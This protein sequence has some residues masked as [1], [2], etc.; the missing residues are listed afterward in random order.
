MTSL[1]PVTLDD[2]Y[3][4]NSGAIVLNAIQALV[5]LPLMQRR[6]DQAQ[7]LN[8]AG[9]I[10]GYRGSPLGGFDKTLWQAQRFLDEHKIKFT[11]GINEDL[12]A[13]AVWGSQQVNL[14]EGSLYDGVFGLWYGKGPGVDRSGDAFK[15]ANAAGT[16]QYGGVVALL[17]DDHACRSSTL[18][19]QS[20]YA[21]M[22]AMIP[23]LNPAHILDILQFGLFGFAL[24]RYSGCWVSL[25]TL[26]EIADSSASIILDKLI[27]QFNIPQDFIMPQGG[28]NIRRPDTPLEQERRLHNFKIPAIQAFVRAN[29]IDNIIYNPPQKRLGIVT[30]G[31]AYLD[32]LEAFNILGLTEEKLLDLGIGL[33]KVGLTWPLESLKLKHF[34]EGYESLFVIEEKRPL[35]ESQARDHLYSLEASKRPQIFGKTHPQ[36]GILLESTYELSPDRIAMALYTLL[37]EK[38]NPS[39]NLLKSIE[40]LDKQ[41]KQ[42]G[43]PS[44]LGQR[45][46]Y[47]CPGCPHNTSTKLPEG[48]EG[49]AGIGCHYMARWMNRKT[50]LFT[51]MGAE[52]VPWIGHAPF[53][54]LPHLFSNLGD[55][56]YFHSG[57]LAIRASVA[58]K[59]NITYKLLYNDAVAMTGG[60][61]VDGTL[62]VSQLANQLWAEGVQKVVI[63]TDD[64]DRYKNQKH[65]YPA[66]VTF[67]DRDD[68]DAVQ[69]Q[70]RDISGVTVLIYEQ[71][72]ATEKRRR[73]KRGLMEDPNRRIFINDAVCEGCGDCGKVSNCV[74]IA[75]L[76]TELGRK[77][78]IDQSACNKDFSCVKGF[79]PSFVSVEGAKIKKTTLSDHAAPGDH[80]LDIPLPEMSILLD[81]SYNI[82]ITGIGGTGIVTIGSLLGMAAHLEGKGCT[83]LD[84]TGLAQ[85]GGPVTSHLRISSSPE[86]ENASRIPFHKVDVVLAA[87]LVVTT[88]PDVLARLN[89]KKTTV[90]FDPHETMPGTFTQDADYNLNTQHMVDILKHHIQ[91][92]NM[93]Q[94][95]ANKISTAILGDSLFANIF[96]VG[97]AYQKGLIPLS[98]EAL[99]KA[100]E[101]N[102]ASIADNKRALLWGRRSAIDSD[103]VHRAIAKQSE[104]ESLETTL[105]GKIKKR[106]KFLKDYQNEAYASRY[107][108]FV[109]RFQDKEKFMGLNEHLLSEAVAKYFFKL[110]AYKDEYEVARL[111][112]H[113]DFMKKIHMQ[114]EGD[115]K[116]KFY[117]APPL[118]SKK[119][120]ETG[121]PQKA[122][123]GPWMLS[124]FNILSRFKFLRG[125]AFDIFGYTQERKM[126][127]Q[128]IKDYEILMDSILNTL[129]PHNYNLAVE[130]ASIP[131]HIRGYGHVKEEHL[132]RAKA[133]EEKLKDEYFK[134]LTSNH[135]A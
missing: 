19:H 70:L 43:T 118:F 40:N 8:T 103:Y 2:K 96:L 123:Y 6:L 78:A 16:S 102:G 54:T 11:P 125:T 126:E 23:V 10:S 18:P 22:D 81:H 79:C 20:E 68:L 71:T 111:Y 57:I 27:T 52:G 80:L 76:E 77:R 133:H 28:L 3:S 30:T 95:S 34:A 112:T 7:G 134:N 58:A 94:I 33:Y 17:G 4:A 62:S 32:T 124:A 128:L 49:L 73:R 53:T 5:R 88:S 86:H 89:P 104:K 51:H 93:H 113:P 98:L 105:E 66:D 1:A 90:I 65:L 35:I 75:P 31:K 82:L 60:Q 74:A 21:M 45:L 61:P 69:K 132:K 39:S 99:E 9:F 127:R 36:L 87:D 119:D 121:L 91:S 41:L 115:M 85:K 116:L 25:K 117:L 63:V 114:F 38:M 84:I 130:I 135:A 97:F 92:E 72:C 12:G 120:K 55:G 24:S 122:E 44:L 29:P 100:I 110:M 15:H 26:E 13:T 109:K 131:E 108:I 64:L 50:D 47:Y 14:F 101:L 106:K 67:H 83:V 56:T 48:S 129:A 59:V 107:E 42:M 46:P 37:K